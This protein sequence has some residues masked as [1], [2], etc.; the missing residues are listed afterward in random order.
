MDLTYFCSTKVDSITK[1][2]EEISYGYDGSLVTAEILS[3]TLNQ[4]LTYGY[5]NDFNLTSFTYGGGT[6]SYSYDNDGL[7]D[8][9]WELSPLAE[10][11]ETVCQSR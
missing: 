5:N 4:S 11:E 6:V 8:W 9:G 10:M 3:G 2:T 7:S 1:G